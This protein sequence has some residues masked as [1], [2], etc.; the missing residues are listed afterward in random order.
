MLTE[1]INYWVETLGNWIAIDHWYKVGMGTSIGGFSLSQLLPDPMLINAAP[2]IWDKVINNP[3]S[4][5]T[6]FG[7]LLVNVVAAWQKVQQNRREE[8]KHRQEIE[9]DKARH[10]LEINTKKSFDND[11]G[12]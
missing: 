2:T 6:A 10:E 1:T 3:V 9:Q 7:I 8:E 5:A 4:L 11:E 12:V